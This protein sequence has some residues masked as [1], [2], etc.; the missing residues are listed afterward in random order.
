MI[1]FL[2]PVS[3]SL[4]FWLGCGGIQCRVVL[5]R[6]QLTKQLLNFKRSLESLIEFKFQLGCIAGIDPVCDLPLQEAGSVLESENTAVLL[7][8]V[9]HYRDVNSCTAQV[10]G[11][12]HIRYRDILDSWIEQ[13]DN[14]GSTHN[15]AN[16]LGDFE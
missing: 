13:I 15:L 10:S 8:F 1:V 4:D 12:F 16:C 14:D 3:A 2:L 11:N 7:L 9:A 6:E 5:V